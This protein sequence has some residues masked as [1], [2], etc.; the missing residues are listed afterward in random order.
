[1]DGAFVSCEKNICVNEN[2]IL[3]YVFSQKFHNFRSFF[4]IYLSFGCA[5][6]LLLC[7][8]FSLVAASGGCCLVAVHELLVEVA[9]L[10]AELSCTCSVVTAHR[11]SCSMACGIFPD[12]GLIPCLLYWQVDSLPQSH[13]GSPNCSSFYR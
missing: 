3:S 9:S 13:Q 12:Q 8:H 1:M 7:G 4:Y 6:S 2:K 11:L 5:G 10:V